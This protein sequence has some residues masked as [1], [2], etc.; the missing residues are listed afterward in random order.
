MTGSKE[1]RT[2]AMNGRALRRAEE[3]AR[4]EAFQEQLVQLVRQAS[5]IARSLRVAGWGE[6]HRR[7][8]GWRALRGEAFEFVHRLDRTVRVAESRRRRRSRSAALVLMLALGGG[9]A[10]AGVATKSG[11][12]AA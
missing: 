8:S 2:R 10:A 5:A 7:R 1:A 11:P 6:A 4:D 9:L 12:R 3:L